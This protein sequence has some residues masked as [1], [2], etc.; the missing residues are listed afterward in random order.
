[1]SILNIVPILKPHCYLASSTCSKLF[2][3]YLWPSPI[4]PHFLSLVELS[5][6]MKC[7]VQEA[8]A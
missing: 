2:R 7:E 4:L 5:F 8:Q 6:V 3:H 1:M